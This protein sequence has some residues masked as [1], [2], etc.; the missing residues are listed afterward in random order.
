MWAESRKKSDRSQ[1]RLSCE[2]HYLDSPTGDKHRE[3]P[4]QTAVGA[5]RSGRQAKEEGDDA[6]RSYL[7]V[8]VHTRARSENGP[9]DQMSIEINGRDVGVVVH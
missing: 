5:I 2:T 4:A 8:R 1:G 3:H 6:G 9:R 7:D